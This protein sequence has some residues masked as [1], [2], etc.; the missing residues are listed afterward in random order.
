MLS[1]MRNRSATLSENAEYHQA[2][3][4]QGKL[5]ERIAKVEEI[6]RS[7]QVVSASGGDIVQIGSKVTVTKEG[8]SEE[9]SIRSSAPKKPT[10]RRE[11]SSNKSPFGSALFG[12]KKG[13]AVSFSYSRRR[14]QL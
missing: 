13:D 4:D 11:K 9:K 14:S 3:E 10:W 2:R 12:K 1:N 5:E 8:G 7:S 6:L